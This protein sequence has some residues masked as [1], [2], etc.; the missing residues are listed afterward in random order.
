MTNV[1]D[2]P[3]E[4]PVASDVVVLR[5]RSIDRVLI[6]LGLLVAI[7][8]A[9]AGGL[10]TWGKNFAHDYVH[11]ELSSQKITFPTKEAVDKEIADEQ[12]GNNPKKA[13]NL[14]NLER[15]A[16]HAGEALTSGDQAEAYAGYIQTHAN[17][18]SEGLSYAEMG[19]PQRAAQAAVKEAKDAGKP[20]AEIDAL[21]AEATKITQA[22]ETVFKGETL[23]GLLLSTYAWSTIGRI[24]G[25][26]A[27]VAFIAAVLMLILV[28]AGLVHLGRSGKIAK[29]P[30]AS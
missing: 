16:A 26:A 19:T 10:L 12:A 9:V 27:V 8:L 29:A 20:Q 3:V 17:H 4:K 30:A 25:I 28:G 22:R 2:K 21:Q 6:S 7:V 14:R 23:R 11:D 13:E 1:M 5:R 18:T 24:A 15:V